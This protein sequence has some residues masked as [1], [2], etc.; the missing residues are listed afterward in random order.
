M[1]DNPKENNENVFVEQ[2][3][4]RN[5][6]DMPTKRFER[7][8]KGLHNKPIL[9]QCEN[10]GKQSK[11][12]FKKSR[13][14]KKILHIKSLGSASSNY[15]AYEP[16]RKLW[17]AYI[18]ELLLPSDGQKE[19][20]PRNMQDTLLKAD[21]HGAN[22]TVVKS[23]CKTFLNV[24]GTIIMESKNIF[25]IVSKKNKIIKIPKKNSVFEIEY[26]DYGIT[27]FGDQFCI[28]PA[29]R[30]TKKFKNYVSRMLLV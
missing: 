20:D 26:L 2:F 8:V 28:K 1:G 29:H 18:D 13:A 11:K 25:V 24:C 21:F 3:L 9:L 4:K 10:S 17:K 23:K 27:L 19:L 6:L 7:V 22:I 5:L 15:L 16:L 14:I 12:K 30:L